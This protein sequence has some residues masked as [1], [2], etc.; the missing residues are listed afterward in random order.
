MARI[1]TRMH[2]SP[3]RRLQAIILVAAT[4]LS[5]DHHRLFI[6]TAYLV[7]ARP[8]NHDPDFAAITGGFARPHILVPLVYA[9][10]LLCLQEITCCTSALVQHICHVKS[11]A[12]QL[13][14]IATRMQGA[15]NRP[16]IS[17]VVRF[18]GFYPLHARR[19][20]GSHKYQ[21]VSTGNR[22]TILAYANNDDY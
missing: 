10:P 7:N 18:E 12:R 4:N 8:R 1:R 13:V 17:K 21:A 11:I 22:G 5:I 3:Y 14:N 20:I 19:S 15:F 9:V 16:P 2:R 6:C